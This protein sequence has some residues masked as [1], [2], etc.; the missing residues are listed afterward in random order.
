MVE[1]MPQDDSPAGPLGELMAR[2]DA[3]RH[4][5]AI[6]GGE[7]RA[8]LDAALTELDTAIDAL[9]ER[10]EGFGDGEGGA[11]PDTAQAERRLLRAAFQHA[12]VPLFLLERDGTVRRANGAAGELIGAS[13]GYATGKLLTAFADPPSRAALR[14]HL[15]AAARTGKA[16]QVACRLLGPQGPVD[17]TMAIRALALPG[18]PR[19]L[20]AGVTA[21]Q[22]PVPQGR[23]AGGAERAP[24][25]AVRSMAQRMDMITAVTR[26]L[27]DNSTFS[28]AV[29]VQRCARLLAGEIASWVIINIERDGRLQRQFATGP[30]DEDAERLAR[31]IRAGDPE[32]GTV[33]WQ[34][35][36]TGKSVLLAHVEDEA[37]LGA[38]A[39]GTPLLMLLGA[40]SVLSVPISD[41]STTY[42]ALTLARVASE[43]YFDVAD[44]ALAE[45]LAEHL[46]IAIGVDR[47]FRRGTEVAQALQASLLPARLP[48]VP[49]LDFAAAYIAASDWQEIS[50]DFYDVFPAKGEDDV[51]DGWG[52]VV[53]DVCGKGEEA[54]TITAAAR[55]AV[56]AI[57]H[58]NPHPAEVL[59]KVNSVLLTGGFDE[60]F[61]TAS[62][63]YLRPD[64]GKVRVL[65]AGAG[66]PGPGLVRSDGRVEVL[67][68]GGMPLGLFDSAEPG[69]SELVLAPGDLLFFYTDGVTDARGT[70]MSYFQDRLADQ[71]A[72]VAGQSAAATVR[73]VQ[74]LVTEF[75]GG[76]LRDDMTMLA[77]KVASP[78]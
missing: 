6:P 47:M 29:T 41:G 60:R 59:G 53:G 72:S 11:A 51:V 14:T 15:A 77:V 37:V 30:R 23:N 20:I 76:E 40:T 74:E 28:E 8:L 43:G 44:L 2:R 35:H 7:P 4:A 70:D 26:L 25:R 31:T 67:E 48:R 65:L 73:A 32:P 57:A 10:F 50:G 34:V 33:C 75:S 5:L 22:A 71:L 42:G 3:L 61:V 68:C 18:D 52:I 27:L 9:T 62:L 69:T 21:G 39:G 16:R 45:E 38:D 66:H 12:P 36:A 17:V 78:A 64:D 24:A 54:A 19:L 55:H 63:A 46:A 1:N 56:R 13:A 58:D 49:G